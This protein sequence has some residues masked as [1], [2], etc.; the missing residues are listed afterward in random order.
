[1]RH[2]GANFFRQFKN[3]QLMNM[4]KRLCGENDQRKFNTLW[5]K[6][7]ELTGKQ[8][9]EHLKKSKGSHDEAPLALCPLPT[10]TPTTR[11]RPGSVVKNF[12]QWIENEPKREVV[13]FV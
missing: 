8:I 5:Q 7:D 11:R 6:I 3:K 12:S 9:K 2:M 10:D 13:P 4:F 1:M